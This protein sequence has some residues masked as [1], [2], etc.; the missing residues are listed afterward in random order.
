MLKGLEGKNLKRNEQQALKNKKSEKNVGLFAQL[1]GRVQAEN[2][3]S[4]PLSLVV[5]SENSGLP[6]G[7]ETQR[8][9]YLIC[10]SSSP[11]GFSFGVLTEIPCITKRRSTIK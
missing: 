10:A 1:C 9:F 5:G 11:S 7:S 3:A 2:M 4:V 6:R 8:S